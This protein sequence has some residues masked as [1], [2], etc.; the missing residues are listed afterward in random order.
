MKRMKFTIAYD[1]NGFSGFQVQPKERT[2]QG[3]LERALSKV[4]K[5]QQVS[6]Y[7]S[8][9]T[10]ANVHAVGQVIHF[11][12]SLF[13]PSDRWIR[14]L[15]TYLPDDIAIKKVE[16]VSGDFHARFSA[17]QK[18]YR[19]RVLLGEHHDVFRR[20]YTHHYRFPVSIEKMREAATY[21]VGT[22]D[23]TSFCSNKANVDNKTRTIYTIELLE[24]SDE[25][26]FRFVGNSFLYNMVRILVGTILEVGRNKKNPTDILTILE[27]RN[28][29]TAGKTAPGHGLYLWEVL[30][31]NRS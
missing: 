3:E 25:L 9:R 28:R 11:D 17:I 24:E 19:Y 30:Y 5:G 22:H 8:G 15:R 23:F 26:I 7:G 20:A 10:D 14:A 16:E 31:D 12:T 27:A 4:H 6:V 18:E 2:V 29:S 13:L 1:G 21:L